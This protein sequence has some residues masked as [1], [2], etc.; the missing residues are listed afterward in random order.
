MVYYEGNDEW[1]ISTPSIFSCLMIDL[2]QHD[3][4]FDRKLCFQGC[5]NRER[6][7]VIDFQEFYYF[8]REPLRMEGL[9]FLFNLVL[10]FLVIQS[11]LLLFVILMYTLT[12]HGRCLLLIWFLIWFQ[13]CI[14]LF[15]LW[16]CYFLHRGLVSLPKL[17]IRMFMQFHNY[18]EVFFSHSFLYPSFVYKLLIYDL[19][20][21]EVAFYYLTRLS[22]SLLFHHD[23]MG[24]KALLNLLRG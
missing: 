12:N 17:M 11:N 3:K 14:L 18:M 1:M 15:C 13:L 8:Q 20:N 9:L 2:N 22:I 10:S 19:D 24:K 5:E 23:I 6:L 21:F 16:K 7:L 4:I